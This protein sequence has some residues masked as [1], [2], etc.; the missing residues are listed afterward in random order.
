M[1]NEE[2]ETIDSQNDTESTE[3][4]NEESVESTETEETDLQAE[5][6]KAT[7]PLYARMK[8][9][10]EEAKKLKAKLAGKSESSTEK[11][12]GE[13][14]QKDLL[15]LISAKVHEDDIDDIVEYAT[16]KK[17][18]VAEALKSDVV[19]TILS[20]KA[21]FRKT[22]EVSNTGTARRGATKVSDD[23]L[24]SNLSK[25]EIPEPGSEEAERLFYAR[26]G[27]QR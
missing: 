6:K 19:K 20:N 2:E 3:N 8:Q 24:L 5:V 4:D 22:A 26:R 25:G 9:A 21:E 14:P 1:E 10:E 18:S 11:S 16:F 17:I 27:G 15:A 7:A 23:T 12:K 13:L